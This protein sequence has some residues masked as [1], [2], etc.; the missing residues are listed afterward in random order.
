[1]LRACW[2]SVLGKEGGREGGKEGGGDD[3]LFYGIDWTGQHEEEGGREGRKERKGC[4]DCS[5]HTLSQA[6]SMPKEA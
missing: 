3:D 6:S 2:V 4:R 5:V 1:M